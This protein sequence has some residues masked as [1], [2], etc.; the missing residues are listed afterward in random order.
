[1]DLYEF[2]ASLLYIER[3]PGQ[4]VLHKETLSQKNKTKQN[5]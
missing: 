2:K 1:V 4:P 5:N 3:I